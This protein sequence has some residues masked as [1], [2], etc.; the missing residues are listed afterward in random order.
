M[1]KENI[2]NKEETILRIY[3]D[4]YPEDYTFIVSREFDEVILPE[5]KQNILRQPRIIA[6][7]IRCPCEREYTLE[8]AERSEF[9]LFSSVEKGC[10]SKC[11][12]KLI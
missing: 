11:G 2:I 12:T 5:V 3:G 8:E 10:C 9:Q 7:I 4:F 1:V 6:N